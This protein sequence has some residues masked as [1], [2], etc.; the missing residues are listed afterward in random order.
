[1]SVRLLLAVTAVALSL[2]ALLVV[3][4][5]EDV[6]GG[7]PSTDFNHSVTEQSAATVHTQDESPQVSGQWLAL[8]LLLAAAT[9]VA[10]FTSLYLIR[11]RRLRLRDGT[12]V[13][14][15]EQWGH[16]LARLGEVVSASAEA[17]QRSEEGGSRTR[18]ETANDIRDIHQ[19]LSVFHQSLSDR[20][21]E[22]ARL[23][24]G[25]DL[26]VF[27][28]FVTRFVR[29]DQFLRDSCEYMEHGKAEME[30]A[31]KLMLDALDECGIEVFQPDVGADSRVVAGLSDSPKAVPT[32]D[33]CLD[34]TIAEVAEN[35]YKFRDGECIV[36]ARV[37][38]YLLAKEE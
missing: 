4:S 13:L 11:W 30:K 19:L 23:R 26:E 18:A 12:Q 37:K 17:I 38:I 10:V 25:Y 28:Q 21:S 15:P 8:S 5:F 34:F 29:V 24:K 36:P 7:L 16:Y 9:C 20:D 35:G 31:R 22:I 27:R 2:F 1:M 6:S 3:Y 14:V 32:S 33:P